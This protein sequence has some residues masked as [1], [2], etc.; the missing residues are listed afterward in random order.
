[1]V[2]PPCTWHVKANRPTRRMIFL[3]VGL[4][5]NPLAYDADDPGSILGRGTLSN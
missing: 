4:V 1:M 5:D 3:F 2:I